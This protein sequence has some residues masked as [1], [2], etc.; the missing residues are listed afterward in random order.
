MSFSFVL[1]FLF[2]ASEDSTIK[3]WNLQNFLLVQT[4]MRHESG[5]NCLVSWEAERS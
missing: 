3:I 1:Q 2:S 4:L 5:V